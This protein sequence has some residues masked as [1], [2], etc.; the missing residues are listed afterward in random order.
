M[1]A[2]GGS[3]GSFAGKLLLL[4]GLALACLAGCIWLGWRFYQASGG[5]PIWLVPFGNVSPVDL[6]VLKD[7]LLQ[8]D[9][10]QAAVFLFWMYAGP[11]L[12]LPVALAGL[13][14]LLL[15]RFAPGGTLF[16]R[17]ITPANMRALVAVP[18][19]YALADYV[20]NGL[21]LAYFCIAQPP[22][23]VMEN[24]PVALPWIAS[25]KMAFFSVT[26]ILVMRFV[27]LNRL[28]V[29]RPEARR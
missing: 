13:G 14:M 17:P 12:I 28:G 19:V 11:D 4:A 6:H 10:T 29:T 22:A 23:W 5:Y 18:L 21:S 7:L 8:P 2:R 9:R 26:A 3:D 15:K 27:I 25:F 16:R 1:D 20:E 24:A